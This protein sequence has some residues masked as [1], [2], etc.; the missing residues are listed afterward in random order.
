M[1]DIKIQTEYI[2]LGAF[3][4]FAGVCATGGEAAIRIENGEIYVN[5]ET[6]FMRGRKLHV[7]D[8]VQAAGKQ[9][10]VI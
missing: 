2:K 9:Y 1:E 5:G 4:K 7:G 10:R 8:V 3:L 6:C